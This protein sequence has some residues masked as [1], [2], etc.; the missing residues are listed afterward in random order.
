MKWAVIAWMAI[1][2]ASAGPAKAQGDMLRI[3]LPREIVIQ[4]D[5]IRLGQV[6]IFRGDALLQAKAESV[7]LGKFA[8]TGQQ[9]M[10]DRVSILS[11]LASSG[12]KADQVLLSGAQTVLVRRDEKQIHPDRIEAVARFFLETVMG[13]DR[14][15]ELKVL[16]KPRA[17]VLPDGSG[18]I[19]LRPQM[20]QYQVKGTRRVS[21]EIVKDNKVLGRREVAFSLRFR[22]RRAV[23]TEEIP[24]GTFLTN[25]NMKIETV[26]S[27]TAEPTDWKPPYGQ[28]AQRLV[29]SG[30]VIPDTLTAPAEP[31]IVVKRRQMVVVRLESPLLQLSW[32]GEALSDGRVGEI[33]K[34]KMG[35]LRNGRIITAR[36]K[37]D[38]TLEPYREGM[39]IWAAKTGS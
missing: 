33:I 24:A 3:Y 34:V 13:S 14:L 18:N 35:A 26:E 16:R 22:C 39:N 7:E 4:E 17:W 23:A 9:V 21:V 19:D 36:V 10:L 8:L 12:I 2:M 32:V 31:I 20:G 29:R 27:D 11:R 5:V 37:E 28:V 1:W 25:Q 6:G 30:D 15:C 38:G